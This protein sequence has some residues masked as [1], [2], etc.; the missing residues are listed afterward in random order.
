MDRPQI[1]ELVRRA[2][3]SLADFWDGCTKI[4]SNLLGGLA[5]D[6]PHVLEDALKSAERGLKELEQRPP[7]PQNEFRPIDEILEGAA[8]GATKDQ[9]DSDEWIDG[10]IDEIC[11]T[12]KGVPLMGDAG[13][14]IY[15]P[16]LQ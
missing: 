9:I 12:Y 5:D 14:F 6:V 10:I 4:E 2:I 16:D 11:E 3:R 1:R 8:C 7:K 13:I 15:D